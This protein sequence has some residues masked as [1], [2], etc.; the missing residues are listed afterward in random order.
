MSSNDELTAKI[1]Q[2][3]AKI[4]PSLAAHGGGLELVS[5]KGTQATFRIVGAC[6]GC[7][8][9]QMTFGAEMEELIKTEI[10]EI[11]TVKFTA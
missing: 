8:Y 6:L 11:K 5:V 9:S 2:T 7:P 10:P 1:D 3:L 4:K